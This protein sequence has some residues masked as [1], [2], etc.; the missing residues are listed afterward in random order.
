VQQPF[1][2][3]EQLSKLIRE[4]EN[5]LQILF[6]DYPQS[7]LQVPACSSSNGN[8]ADASSS[9]SKGDFAE[10]TTALGGNNPST[11]WRGEFIVER[12]GG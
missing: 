12:Q 11:I 8:Q 3:I 10:P 1:F 5:A 2:T 7:L 9:A 6:P 4:C